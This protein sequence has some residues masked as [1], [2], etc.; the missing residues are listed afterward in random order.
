MTEGE[1]LTQYQEQ[2]WRLA[3]K[4]L[5]QTVDE[6]NSLME[7]RDVKTPHCKRCGREMNQQRFE[8][9]SDAADALTLPYCNNEACV[10]FNL[11][12]AKWDMKPR[13]HAADEPIFK[14]KT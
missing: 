5:Q 6:Y 1:A 8:T 9:G 14:P 11:C 10:W 13:Q 3:E 2:L 12:V 7:R 4:Q